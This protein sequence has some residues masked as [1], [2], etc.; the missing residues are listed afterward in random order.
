MLL[1]DP[2]GISVS[3]DGMNVS[4]SILTPALG[5]SVLLA[6][7]IFKPNGYPVD[8]QLS[9]SQ[10]GTKAIGTTHMLRNCSN[11]GWV[12]SDRTY[13]RWETCEKSV[14]GVAFQDFNL[15]II[16]TRL[17][18]TGTWTCNEMN[19]KISRS[20]YLTVISEYRMAYSLHHT[21]PRHKGCR[22]PKSLREL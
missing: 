17:R 14:A 20:I 3:A 5:G 1:M 9:N 18:D 6:C 15:T 7:R 21:H 2:S 12:I 11:N 13:Y 16:K 19:A 22:C 8:W 10:L 4:A